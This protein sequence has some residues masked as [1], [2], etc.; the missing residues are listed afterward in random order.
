M[1]TSSRFWEF[2][3]SGAALEIHPSSK[4][5]GLRPFCAGSSQAPVLEGRRNNFGD[6]R[7]A[8]PRTD[9]SVSEL[10]HFRT[11]AAQ[12]YADLAQAIPVESNPGRAM[13]LGAE[14]P[15]QFFFRRLLELFDLNAIE[16][17][18]HLQHFRTKLFKTKTKEQV[19]RMRTALAGR[20]ASGNRTGYRPRRSSLAGEPS[21]Y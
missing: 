16:A 2:A 11:A 1:R 17:G 10:H 20:I 9:P 13:V 14:H 6:C 21:W 12:R 18:E 8:H 4:T 19:T 7:C 3:I 15:T 5:H